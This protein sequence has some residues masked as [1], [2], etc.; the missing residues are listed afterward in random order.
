MAERAMSAVM[1]ARPSAEWP[2]SRHPV[3]SI[4][5]PVRTLSAGLARD[6]QR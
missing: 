4:V 6:L 5:P 3:K 2:P 1:N